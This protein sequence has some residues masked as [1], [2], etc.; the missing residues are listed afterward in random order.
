MIVVEPTM[1]AYAKKNSPLFFCE[2]DELD[3]GMAL[4]E[5]IPDIQFVDGSLWEDNS[6]PVR[7]SIHECRERIVFLWSRT[8]CPTLPYKT[9]SD[10]KI[11]GPTS[12][13]VIQYMRC[14]LKD[15]VLL[16][17]DIGI[18]YEKQD[19]AIAGFVKSVWKVMKSMNVCA[20]NSVNAQTG[21]IIESNITDY[22]VGAGAKD[23][24]GSGKLLKH[25]AADVYYKA[26]L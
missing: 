2:R 20:L 16:S 22:F 6:P 5:F 11:H 17:G 21:D 4:K 10:G 1:T 23:W 25:C 15:P 13:V 19:I 26:A 9:L 24:T 18:G 8:A 3:F 14:V 12:G 7:P